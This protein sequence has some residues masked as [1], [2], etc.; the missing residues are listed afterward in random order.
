[1][2]ENT[3]KVLAIAI[4]GATAVGLLF[5]IGNAHAEN[6]PLDVK[7]ISDYPYTSACDNRADQLRKQG[8][9]KQGENLQ[10]ACDCDPEATMCWAFDNKGDISAWN[11]DKSTTVNTAKGE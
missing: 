11:H 1:M 5:V 6:Q 9:S 3:A 7:L 4:L 10:I 8:E 2:N